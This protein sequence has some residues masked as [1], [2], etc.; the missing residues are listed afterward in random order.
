MSKLTSFDKLLIIDKDIFEFKT[1][2]MYA[3]ENGDLV[4]NI[5]ENEYEV[6]DKFVDFYNN[7]DAE[8]IDV[9]FQV[10]NAWKTFKKVKVK[11]GSISRGHA[12][13]VLEI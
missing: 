9:G 4:V 2:G 13:V 7:K 8:F 12:V 10:N 11:K 1:S 6:H 5:H 3:D